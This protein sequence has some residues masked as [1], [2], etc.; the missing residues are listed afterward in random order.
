MSLELSLLTGE[1]CH[2]SRAYAPICSH[3]DENANLW[4]IRMQLTTSLLNPNENLVV[5]Y[6][7][8]ILGQAC[9]GNEMV[10]IVKIKDEKKISIRAF[11][12]VFSAANDIY[13]HSISNKQLL[14]DCVCKCFSPN[15]II[16]VENIAIQRCEF[17]LERDTHVNCA[18]E[19]S[20][21]SRRRG[22]D[23]SPS[24]YISK[25]QIPSA[26]Y[27]LFSL[28]HFH[29]G[30]RLLSFKGK[31]WNEEEF[32]KH[33]S[34]DHVAYEYSLTAQTYDNQNIV[35]DPTEHNCFTIPIAQAAQNFAPFINEPQPNTTCNTETVSISSKKCPLRVDVVATRHIKP[36][37]EITMLYL[38]ETNKYT[39][40]TATLPPLE[41]VPL[42]AVKKQKNT[43]IICLNM[44]PED[45]HCYF[46]IMYLLQMYLDVI[47]LSRNEKPTSVCTL[48]P[49][50]F[51]NLEDIITKIGNRGAQIDILV[52][53]C[54]EWFQ[55][56]SQNNIHEIYI[57][58]LNE[59]IDDCLYMLKG[60]RIEFIVGNDLLFLPS[61]STRY[62][63]LK[64]EK[65]PIPF[66]LVYTEQEVIQDRMLSDQDTLEWL[67]K[68]GQTKTFINVPLSKPK[69]AFV[70]FA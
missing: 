56:V 26:G 2:T 55:K 52:E 66:C 64:P 41:Y 7:L 70:F 4:C 46:R 10:L 15:Q 9:K 21:P 13:L 30:D 31:Q 28:Q 49:L 45:N 54:I 39:F 63:L 17:F 20:S 19:L 12:T 22:S 44:H 68:Y 33:Y 42:A 37:D 60:Y 8:N 32:Y 24:F 36:H 69:T 11:A 38:R 1:M 40:G 61:T 25:S 57:P 29:R 16:Y 23:R 14:M 18:T 47:C 58:M 62:I 53:D 67:T 43:V 48:L 27:G 59:D 3:F 50:T 5:N 65:N 6:I 35:F 51:S 34:S